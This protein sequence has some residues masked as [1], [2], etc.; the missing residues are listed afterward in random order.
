LTLEQLADKMVQA[1][2]AF[3]INLDGG[4]SSVLVQRNRGVISRPTCLDVL[5]VKC[6]RPVASVLCL[7][8]Q[9]SPSSSKVVE[10]RRFSLLRKHMNEIQD[11]ST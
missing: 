11:Y 1:G 4:S 3:A 6:E 7:V 9:Q 5:P 2:A 10:Q 8:Q